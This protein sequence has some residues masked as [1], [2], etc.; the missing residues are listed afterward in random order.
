MQIKIQSYKTTG[1]VQKKRQKLTSEFHG[2]LFL[3][4]K[5]DNFDKMII[6]KYLLLTI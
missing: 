2:V 1:A 4:K 6:I 3:C 5:I